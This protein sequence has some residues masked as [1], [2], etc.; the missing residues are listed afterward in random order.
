MY[1][2]YFLCFLLLE[3]CYIKILYIARVQYKQGSPFFCNKFITYHTCTDIRVFLQYIVL[4][5]FTRVTSLADLLKSGNR[6][7]KKI[8]SR[9]SFC[10]STFNKRTAPSSLLK[11]GCHASFNDVRFSDASITLVTDT[12]ASSMLL[13]LAIGN[14]IVKYVLQSCNIVTSFHENLLKI[15]N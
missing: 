6:K 3:K 2:I 10:Y 5:N 4:P 1:K 8:F 11:A 7:P 13:L 15:Q 12:C 14:E 9:P